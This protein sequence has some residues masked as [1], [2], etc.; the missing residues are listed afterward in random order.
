MTYNRILWMPGIVK[1]AGVSLVLH[2]GFSIRGRP[3]SVGDFAPNSLLVHHDASPKG[4]SPTMDSYIFLRGRPPGTPPPLSQVWICMGCRGRHPVGT[5]HFGASGRANHAGVGSGWGKIKK[6]LG[7]ALSVGF[8]TDNTVGEHTPDAM[9]DSIVLGWAAIC[10]DRRWDPG[11]S[12]GSHKEYAKGR[13]GDPDDINMPSL[14]AAIETKMK[15]L[16][17]SPVQTQPVALSWNMHYS[18]RV[19]DTYFSIASRLPR[20]PGFTVTQIAQKIAAL[21]NK[22][23]LDKKVVLLLPKRPVPAP[24]KPVAKR[25]DLPPWPGVRYV[26]YGK[27]N[28]YVLEMQRKLRKLA[29]PER[30][31]KLNPNGATGFYGSET[32]AL[33]RWF[34]HKVSGKG[35]GIAGPVTWNRLDKA[36]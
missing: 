34:Q 30:V 6:N 24:H 12:C 16:D 15:R 9:Y 11:N 32:R 25:I 22:K 35:S 29:G 13:K 18:V 19:G 31:K 7:N 33:V 14:R 21:N 10:L 28:H 4:P 20:V 23:K 36:V 2:D 1:G 26:A 8:E 27:Q 17:R 5:W 3:P